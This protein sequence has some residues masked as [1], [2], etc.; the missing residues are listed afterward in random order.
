MCSI[1]TR[2]QDKRHYSTDQLVEHLFRHS[3]AY[4]RLAANPIPKDQKN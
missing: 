4:L 1:A 2:F 3:V